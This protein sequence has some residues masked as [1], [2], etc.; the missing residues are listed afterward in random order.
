MAAAA[1][2]LQEKVESPRPAQSQ[3]ANDQTQNQYS[4]NAPKGSGPGS[5]AQAE[6]TKK[7]K[8]TPPAPAPETV[9]GAA[10]DFNR[11]ASIQ[12]VSAYDAGLI[13]APGSKILWRAGRR[14]LI[15]F[16]ADGGVSWS[17]QTSGVIVDLLS[18]AAPSDRVCWIVGRVGAILLTTDGG[19][20]WRRIPAPIS[21]DLD[22][23]QATDAL[24]ATIW[25]VQNK[26]SFET[27]DGG[28]IWKRVTK[29]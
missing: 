23:I 5:L 25:N 10:R 28:L 18:G 15:E 7:M 4:Y 9:G 22:G 21:D 6:A 1:G 12:A 20:H 8:T 29:E 3:T 11:A 17:R 26:K 2:A 24:H 13:S 19:A 27:S 14:G 16:S